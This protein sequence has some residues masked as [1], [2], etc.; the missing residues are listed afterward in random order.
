MDDGPRLVSAPAGAALGASDDGEL[1]M[2]S[3]APIARQAPGAALTQYRW[4]VCALLFLA[5]TINYVDRQ[6]LSLLKPILDTELG[7]TQSAIRKG[8]RGFSGRLCGGPLLFGAFVDRFGT[9]I[10][11]A[12]S[13]RPGAWPPSAMRWWRAWAD[14]SARGSRSASAK[15]GTSR[16]PSKAVAQWFPQKERAFATAA[17]Q[18]GRQRGRH[19][20]AGGRPVDRLHVGLAFGFRGRRRRRDSLALVVAARFIADLERSELG[21]GRARARSAS[22]S[23]GKRSATEG[24]LADILGHRQAWAFIVAKFLTDPVWW[25]FLIWLPDYFKKTRGLDIKNSWV[26]LV[27]IYAIVTVLSIAGGWITGYLTRRGHSVSRARKIDDARMRVRGAAH[28]ARDAG[29][30]LG[31]GSVDRPCGRR[32][33]GVVGQSVHQR[34]RHVPRAGGGLGGGYGRN[35]RLARRD[36]LSRLLG[37]AP[38]SISSERGT[39]RPD[40]PS[41]SRS[42]D[43]LTSSRS[44]SVTCWRPSSTRRRAESRPRRPTDAHRNGSICRASTHYSRLDRNRRFMRAAPASRPARTGSVYL[45]IFLH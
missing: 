41:S 35:G 25:F 8:E 24:A 36:S 20:G 19:R 28:P 43:R 29:E 1:E 42:A 5:T 23:A 27:A 16:P 7:W 34:L 3:A 21:T 13:I 15:A 2:P 17:L 12:V 14:S 18:L 39:L 30:R 45:A 22:G 38:R 37:A 32:A 33:S 4:L 40:T 10:G 26:H 31:R 44:R 9:K 11:Y 6:I